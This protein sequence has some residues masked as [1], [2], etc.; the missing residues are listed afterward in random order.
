MGA[1]GSLLMMKG[2]GRYHVEDEMGGDGAAAE[3]H[4]YGSMSGGGTV[5][6]TKM[7]PTRRGGVTDGNQVKGR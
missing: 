4:A 6:G 2:A 1:G 3:I 7:M 5:K